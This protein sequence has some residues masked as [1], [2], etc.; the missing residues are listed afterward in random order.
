MAPPEGTKALR[1]DLS[2]EADPDQAL[3]ACSLGLVDQDGTRYDFSA[4][5][6]NI[7]QDDIS[8]CVP[9]GHEG[10][11]TP[12]FKG[13]VRSTPPGEERPPAWTMKPV[14]IVPEDATIT[15]VVMWWEKPE[16]LRVS[17]R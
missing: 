12:V 13:Q 2:F 6:D 4:S 17:V 14:V 1:V 16:H 11:E 7:E 3:R 8:P 10:P 5:V 15:H 9:W